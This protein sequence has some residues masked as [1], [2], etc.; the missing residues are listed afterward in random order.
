MA[1]VS[2]DAIDDFALST[3]AY[4]HKQKVVDVSL[5]LTKYIAQSMMF[6]GKKYFPP[7]GKNMIWNIQVDNDDNI[8]YS[9]LFDTDATSIQSLQ[10]QAEL[11]LRKYTTNYSWDIDEELF[12][13]DQTT[14]VNT[15][16]HAGNAYFNCERSDWILNQ[17]CRIG[18]LRASA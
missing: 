13:T 17:S 15:L 16:K 3:L 4:F 1:G 7:I 9:D 12:Q 5:S 14:I 8:K 6:T 11:P 18:R 2:F 10:V